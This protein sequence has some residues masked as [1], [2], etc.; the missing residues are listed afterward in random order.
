MMFNTDLMRVNGDSFGSTVW[1]C[2][3]LMGFNGDVPQSKHIDVKNQPVRKMIFHGAF[4]KSM[5]VYPGVRPFM[6]FVCGV[7]FAAFMGFFHGTV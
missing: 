4:F 5:L 7:I 1:D 2:W 3:G 6:G